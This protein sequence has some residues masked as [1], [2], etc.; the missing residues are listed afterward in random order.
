MTMAMNK[1]IKQL[2]KTIGW[3][4]QLTGRNIN[5]LQ[6]ERIFLWHHYPYTMTWNLRGFINN[7]V[8]TWKLCIPSN[9]IKFLAISL[10]ISGIQIKYIQIPSKKVF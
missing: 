1:T 6:K 3:N 4:W 9:V 8:E 10:I 7:I 5:Q 2:T